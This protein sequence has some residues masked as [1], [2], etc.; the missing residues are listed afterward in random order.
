M[1]ILFHDQ[2]NVTWMTQN[3]STSQNDTQELLYDTVDIAHS[4]KQARNVTLSKIL[5]KMS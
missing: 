2:Q 3:G 5:R 1:I 4:K